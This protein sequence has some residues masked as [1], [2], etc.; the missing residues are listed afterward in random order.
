M[1]KCFICLVRI[2][3]K[4]LIA[5]TGVQRILPYT[6]RD[7]VLG[8]GYWTRTMTIGKRAVDFRVSERRLFVLLIC[9][10]DL[11]GNFLC[12]RIC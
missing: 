6:I 7:Q 11:I 2:R 1:T 12:K 5:I 9:F 10:F 8:S 4:H 3:V